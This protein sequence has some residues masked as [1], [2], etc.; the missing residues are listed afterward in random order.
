M[1][2]TWLSPPFPTIMPES[3]RLALGLPVIA[4]SLI[5]LDPEFP[6]TT[7]PLLAVEVETVEALET[8]DTL[9][10]DG[11]FAAAYVTVAPATAVDL[12]LAT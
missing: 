1:T 4:Q 2:F 8:T 5:W 11:D 9:D 12:E 7:Q 6:L 3:T 10:G